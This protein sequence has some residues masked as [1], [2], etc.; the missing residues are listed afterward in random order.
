MVSNPTSAETSPI[1]T[2]PLSEAS[3]G[4]LEEFFSRNPWELSDADFLRMIGIYREQRKQWAADEAAGA[5][6]AKKTPKAKVA[7]SLA[8]LGLE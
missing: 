6:R 4:S 1:S 7:V 2:S 5:T 3:A 8:D